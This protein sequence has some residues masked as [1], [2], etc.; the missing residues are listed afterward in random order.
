MSVSAA[1]VKNHQSWGEG[2]VEGDFLGGGRRRNVIF[3][4]GSAVVGG[5]A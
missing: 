4:S 3:V 1:A 5:E 2:S